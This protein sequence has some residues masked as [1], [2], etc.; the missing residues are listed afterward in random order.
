MALL[1]KTFQL[2]GQ[3]YDSILFNYINGTRYP[4]P[5][6]WDLLKSIASTLPCNVQSVYRGTDLYSI[7]CANIDEVIE[8][9]DRLYSWTTKHKVAKNIIGNEGDILVMND[10]INVTGIDLRSVNTMQADVLLM[11]ARYVVVDIHQQQDQSVKT[12]LVRQV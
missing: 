2:Y 12:M 1:K 4:I 3:P 8:F 11:P 6:E 7:V 5:S 9:K 10:T